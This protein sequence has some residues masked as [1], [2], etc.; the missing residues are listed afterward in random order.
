MLKM[1]INAKNNAAIM[2][3]GLSPIQARLFG[4][5]VARGH[6]V[7]PF[8]NHGHLLPTPYSLVFLKAYR[9]LDYMTHFHFHGSRFKCLK[10]A[11]RYFFYKNLKQKALY[12]WQ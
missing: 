2:W 3:T 11:Q 4:A 1:G 6:I 5:P 12:K 8:G 9:K 7:P 10:V